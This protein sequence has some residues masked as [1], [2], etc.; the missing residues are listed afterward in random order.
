M[1]H[2]SP[3]LLRTVSL[4]STL[5]S[6]DLVS[7]F[8]WLS[9]VQRRRIAYNL[10]LP[11]IPSLAKVMQFSNNCHFNRECLEEVELLGLASGLSYRDYLLRIRNPNAVPGNSPANPIVIGDDKTDEQSYP[12]YFS[13]DCLSLRS[14][15][16]SNPGGSIPGFIAESV[17]ECDGEASETIDSGD[18]TQSQFEEWYSQL[19]HKLKP[20]VK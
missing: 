11:D 9:L 4:S 17:N 2:L 13:S 19:K 7:L 8:G 14:N 16:D 18:S 12:E 5:V 6:M 1:D 10:V 15:N 3:P 20:T